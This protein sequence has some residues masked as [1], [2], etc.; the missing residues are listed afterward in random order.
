MTP[1]RMEVLLWMARG[2]TNEEIAAIVGLAAPTV[3]NHVQDV[4]AYYGAPTRICAVIQAMA[5]G[6]LT[7]GQVLPS[8]SAEARAASTD[9]G[10]P[11]PGAALT[12]GSGN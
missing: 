4:L 7:L 12:K 1:R 2:K 3:K 6:D 10:S 8:V 11:Q 5:R 9:A